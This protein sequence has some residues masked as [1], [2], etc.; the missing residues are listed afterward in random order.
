MSYNVI[1]LLDKAIAITIKRKEMYEVIEKE[2]C[3]FPPIK[4]MS[5]VFIKGINKTIDYYE[6][7]KKEI[8]NEDAEE[9]NFAIY[10]KMSFLINEFNRRMYD[11][12]INN[13]EEYIRFSINLEKDVLGLLLDIKGRLI[14]QKDDVNTQIYTTLCDII[15]NKANQIK[16][17]EDVLKKTYSHK[18]SVSK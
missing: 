15:E 4:V 7:I 11:L 12:K 16:M 17:L 5:K 8:P 1:D 6:N 18:G 13:V 9:I 14:I 3:D 10:D 2:H